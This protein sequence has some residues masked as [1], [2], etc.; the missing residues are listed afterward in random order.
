MLRP[1]AVTMVSPRRPEKRS[2]PEASWVA[3]SPVA[4]QSVERGWMW[5]LA[6]VELETTSPRT[7]ISPSGL[8]RTSRPGSGLPRV[9]RPTWKG[10]LRVM[11]AVVSVMP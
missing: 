5:P 11:S 1:A 3:R 9:P 8:M 4:N 7:M 6:Q 2:S 10:W